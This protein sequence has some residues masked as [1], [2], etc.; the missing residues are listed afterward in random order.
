[1]AVRSCSVLPDRWIQP[2]LAV[3]SWFTAERW[4]AKVTQPARFTF[5]WPASWLSAVDKSRDSKSAEVWRVW[6]IFDE[7]L[8]LIDAQNVIRLNGALQD[9][10]VSQAWFVWSHAAEAALVGAYCLAGGPE[11][12]RGVKLGRGAARFSEVKTWW[13]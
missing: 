11:P 6:E 1:M 3:R 10:D 9:G 8:Q 2:H 13:P 12:D 7:R 5:L 4:T